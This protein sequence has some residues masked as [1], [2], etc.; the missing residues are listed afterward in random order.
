MD[1]VNIKTILTII[2]HGYNLKQT[3][4]LATGNLSFFKR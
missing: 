1:Y 4:P 2:I 3:A